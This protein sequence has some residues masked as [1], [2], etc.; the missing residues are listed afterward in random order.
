MWTDEVDELVQE[1]YCRLLE[2]G[3]QR[4]R[5]FQG[6]NEKALLSFLAQVARS[7][8]LSHLRHRYASKRSEAL[9]DSQG[10]FRQGVWCDR[11]PAPGER[12]IERLEGVPCVRRSPEHEALRRQQRRTFFRRCRDTDGGRSCRRNAEIVW[13]AL[14]E[15]WNRRKIAARVSLTPSAVDTVVYRARRRLAVY[16]IEIPERL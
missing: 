16:G 9:S 7:V 2:N 5:G 3:R 12:K 11:P 10:T 6:D 1:I 8:V 15:G 14:L 4:L 13:L